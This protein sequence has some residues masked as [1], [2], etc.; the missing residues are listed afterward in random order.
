MAEIQKERLE[1]ISLDALE[2]FHPS[3]KERVDAITAGLSPNGQSP[4]GVLTAAL[5]PADRQH[6]ESHIDAEKAFI[7]EYEWALE[8]TSYA[9][10]ET[11]EPEAFRAAAIEGLFIAGETYD[12]ASEPDFLKHL[13]GELGTYLFEVFGE[14]VPEEAVRPIPA[15]DEFEAFVREHRP[16]IQPE[17]TPQ[18]P[19]Q[20]DVVIVEEELPTQP[21]VRKPVELSAAERLI[22][23]SSYKRTAAY[24]AGELTRHQLN[25]WAAHFPHEV[26]TVNNEYEWIALSMA[27]LD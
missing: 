7:A 23:M 16:I 20:V 22:G 15:F 13:T 27:D 6:P 26:P 24:Y 3:I 17:S 25:V 5:K 1:A 8:L 18:S 2:A 19:E 21:T 12:P 9:Y 14:E 10:A 4:N 11:V